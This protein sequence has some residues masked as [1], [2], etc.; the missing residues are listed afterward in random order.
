MLEIFYHLIGED[1]GHIAWWQMANRAAI[2]FIYAVLLYR[3]APRR[4]F[5]NLSAFD[6]ILTVI[7]GSALSRSL[8]GNAPVLPT[9]AATAFLVVLHTLFSMLA[10]RSEAFSWLAKGRPVRLIRNGE[11][12]WAVARRN[13]LGPRDITEHLRLKGLRNV[14][15]VQEAYIERNGQISVIKKEG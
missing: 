15:Q 7:V 14:E 3:L 1:A 6:I 2:I 13:F 5:A 10:P 11:V 12:D 9:L 8:T 4:A